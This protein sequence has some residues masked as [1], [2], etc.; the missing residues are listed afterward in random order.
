ML[1]LAVLL[2]VIDILA[3]IRRCI[4]FVRS[5]GPKSF[6][7]FWNWVVLNK[8]IDRLGRGPEYTGLVLE[9]PE[10][11]EL[12]KISQDSD[13]DGDPRE[14]AQWAND[15]HNHRRNYSLA[16]EGTVFGSRSPT[17][18]DITLQEKFRRSVTSKSL[19][20]RMG[21]GAFA[22]VERFLV[23]AGF[24]QVLTGIVIYTGMHSSRGDRVLFNLSPC[25]WLP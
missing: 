3:A 1:S 8:D 7:L 22:V 20:H 17:H 13:D 4:S 18:S 14:T 24:A 12:P 9:E 11:L 25:R 15:V 19:I 23:I 10:E 21:N 6:K 16:S 5:D 2:S